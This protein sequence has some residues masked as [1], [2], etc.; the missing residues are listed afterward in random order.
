LL[1]FQKIQNTNQYNRQTR[2][3]LTP[4]ELDVILF[5]VTNPL[6]PPYCV[7]SRV[8]SSLVIININ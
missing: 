4:V 5:Q 8:S 6:L 2:F 7:L 1:F 3:Y